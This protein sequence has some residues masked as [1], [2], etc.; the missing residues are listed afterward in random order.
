MKDSPLIRPYRPA[1]R[2]AIRTICCETADRGEPIENLFSD[3]EIVADLVTRYYTEFEPQ[4]C[5]VAEVGGKVVG[6]LTAAI[7]TRQF[8]RHMVWH[9]ALPA[10]LRAIG[11]GA[12][13]RMETWRMVQAGVR[14]IRSQTRRLHADLDGFPAHV[15]INLLR[16]VR[17]LGTG[18]EL[19]GTFLNHAASFGV[20]GVHATVRADH[21]G[22]RRFFERMGFAEVGGYAVT[23][24]I[25]GGIQKVRTLIYARTIVSSSGRQQ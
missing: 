16:E 6:Y 8:A 5:W 11:R 2:E 12:L 13:F 7:E 10:I 9:I 3:R 20:P 24:P 15:H 1:D 14:N 23:L 18:S 4:S 22:G 21:P 25:R 17:G 19:M